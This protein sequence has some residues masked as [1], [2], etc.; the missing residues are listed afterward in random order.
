MKLPAAHILVL[1]LW[2]VAVPLAADRRADAQQPAPCSVEAEALSDYAHIK[3]GITRREVE[4]YF[5]EDGGAQFPGN[6]RYIYPKCRYLHLDIEFSVQ[7]SA[8]RLGSPADVVT[9]F[10]K[11][12]LD[13]SAKD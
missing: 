1:S 2:A 8:G 10:S 7:G 13:Y 11:I 9:K 5:A 4:K 6:A 12:Y 3:P